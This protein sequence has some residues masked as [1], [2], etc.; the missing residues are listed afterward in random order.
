MELL[1]AT[2]VDFAL[3]RGGRP[4]AGGRWDDVTAV[5]ARRAG[6]DVAIEVRFRDGRTVA[7]HDGMPGW[8]D[9]LDAAEGALPGM[10]PRG[11]WER[12]V[13]ER[14]IGADGVALFARGGKLRGRPRPTPG[15]G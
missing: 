14:P 10:V 12:Q 1:V 15:L 7:A 9:L 6:G 2:A 5:L 8:D 13:G 4:V 3:L 11:A